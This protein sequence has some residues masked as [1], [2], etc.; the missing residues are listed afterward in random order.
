[1]T[2]LEHTAVPILD[3][4]GTEAHCVKTRSYSLPIFPGLPT[5]GSTFYGLLIV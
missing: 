2:Q 4:N 3:I 1:M 5:R